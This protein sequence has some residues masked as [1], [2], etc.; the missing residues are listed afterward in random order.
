MTHVA[1][2]SASV[3]P[4]R[5]RGALDAGVARLAELQGADGSW[6]GDYG[7]PLF[8]SPMYVAAHYFA[9]REIPADVRGEMIR[10]FR[11]VQ[12]PDGGVP[13]HADSDASTMF[14]TT[15]SYVALR[16]L[17][18]ASDDADVVRMREWIRRYGTPLGAA[19]WG[20]WV[21]A[22]LNLYDY[23]GLL[24]VLPE[25]YL[26]PYAVPIHPARFW[27]HAR[28]VY[29]PAAYLYG[30]KVALPEN[31]LIRQ[32]RGELY[33]RPYAQIPFVRYRRH[34]AP[35]DRL[36]PES[37]LMTAAAPV[38]NLAERFHS[39]GLRRRALD[40]LLEHIEYEDRTTAYHR[41]GPVN[42][43]FNTIVHAA[44]GAP[45]DVLER[46]WAGLEKYLQPS[47]DGVKMNGYLSTS[48]WD[49]A[50]AAQALLQ[51]PETPARRPALERAADYLRDNQIR[52]ELV[53]AAKFY[54]DPVRGGWPFC[55]VAHG[56]PI[57][58]CTAEGLKATVGLTTGIGRAASESDLAAARDFLLLYQNADGG[59][60]TYER[61]RGG[62]WL[63]R[64]N[65]SH[66]FCDIMVDYPYVECT[67]ACIQALTQLT[68]F[69]PRLDD[70]RVRAAVRRGADYLLRRQRPDGAWEGS[71]GICYTYGTWF[72]VR[73]L[74]AT[75]F[76][77]SAEPIRR[78]AR[79]LLDRQQADGG[80]GEH[81]RSG[82]ERRYITQSPSLVV[83]TAWALLTLV[84][85]GQARTS[86]AARAAELLVSRQQPDGDWPREPMTG[87]FNRT[88]SINYENY[89]RYF[90]VW[91]LAEY[92]KAT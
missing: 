30:A 84:D 22:L 80:W 25:L 79:F 72:G 91:A 57:T 42:A 9:G 4:A 90:P 2:E 74:K 92:A 58:D 47:A 44:R 51:T 26:L 68:T 37:W 41:I 50:F 60:S 34:T 66:M 64:L 46:S 62:A 6:R 59:W 1:D 55:D 36:Q 82:Y 63:E 14:T 23:R 87:I 78:A 11:H 70:R 45:A 19:S 38:L 73:G 65:V 12:L 27:C 21:L 54:R 17:G 88:T 18:V 39:A 77:T 32:L 3:E 29:L 33:D 52:D 53:D 69:A 76:E 28:Q 67:S 13:L 49:T 8:L 35:T 81:Y 83:N 61:Q 89:R 10:Y 15:L 40:R 75:G 43:V 31:D 16:L 56:W 24:P 7:G 5:V 86:A 48:L 20:K 71:W 85:C